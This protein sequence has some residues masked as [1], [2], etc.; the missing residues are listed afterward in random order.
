M[1]AQ[2]LQFENARVLA[3]LHVNDLKLLKQLEDALEVKVTAR[4]GWLRIEGEPERRDL[5][6]VRKCPTGMSVPK[7][8]IGTTR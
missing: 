3:S 4:D 7:S 1:E 5:R 8:R 6:Q 2:T